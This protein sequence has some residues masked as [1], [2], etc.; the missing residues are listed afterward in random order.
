MAAVDATNPNLAPSTIAGREFDMLDTLL[1]LRD[2]NDGAETGTATETAIAISVEKLPKCT[3][4]V[5]K[6]AIGG[7]VDSSNYWAISVLAADNS[8]MTNATT[9]YDT[10]ALSATAEQ[11]RI[12]LEGKAAELL[13]TSGEDESV[14]LAVK[15]TETGTTAGNITYGAYLT[16]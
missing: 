2:I 14:Y 15:A 5:Q 10:G 12:P 16:K 11:I 3:V 13:R 7:T 8:S 6:N 4:V 1:L 9:L